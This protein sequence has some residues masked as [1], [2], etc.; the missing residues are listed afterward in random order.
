MKNPFLKFRNSLLKRNANIIRLILSSVVIIS[1]SFCNSPS[2]KKNIIKPDQ[3]NGSFPYDLNNP[4]DKYLLPDYLTE[5]SGVSY[6]KNETILCVQ[7]E[8][9][10][11]YA[12]STVNNEKAEKHDFGK[13]GDFEDLT[14]IG[15][16]AYVLRSD[17]TIFEIEN[18]DKESR[19]VKE[20]KTP[21]SDKND[22]EGLTY[23]KSSNSLLIACKGS[24][25]AKKDNPYKGYKAIY[26]FGLQEMKLDKKPEYLVALNKPQ[27]YID[28][29]PKT[30]SLL[31]NTKG[32][33]FTEEETIF[34]PSGLSINPLNDHIYLISSVGKVLVVLDRKGKILDLQDLDRE[35]FQQPEGICFSP[36][37][38]LFISSEGK[39]GKGYILRFGLRKK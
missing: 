38:E 37:G 16:T 25:S 30:G 39:E 36:A 32:L 26:K 4:E 15:R 27:D 24:P 10:M 7:D 1:L 18:F 33:R 34:Q 29:D 22:T 11:I 13:K 14:V 17:G 19:K 5:I 23:D 2:L 21:L 20:Y 12:I 31:M 9:A 8:K 28:F 35:I 6:Y 3:S